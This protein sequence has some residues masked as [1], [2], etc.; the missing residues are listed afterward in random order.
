[1]CQT[2]RIAG[3]PML[4]A[5]EVV[6]NQVIGPELRELVLAAPSTATSIRGGQFVHLMISREAL[7]LRRP[8]SVYRT[9]GDRLHIVY[10]VKGEGTRLL[11]GKLPGDRSMDLI[12]PIG[13]AWPIP[14]NCQRALIVGGGVGAAPLGMLAQELGDR[15][16]E[17]V[18]LLGAQSVARLVG[19]DYFATCGA[20]VTCATDDGS[21]GVT[22][23][24]TE[25]LKELLE[26]KPFDIAYICGPEAMQ[27]KVSALTVFHGIQ[28][29]VSLERLMA[30]GVGACLSCVVPT[31]QGQKRA[32]V[33]GPVFDAE[34]V[35]WDEASL[36]RV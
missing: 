30:C 14:E 6:S 10:H 3:G 26:S 27:V 17:T 4:E 36:A 9:D 11:A 34:E 20:S 7:T 2:S 5:V 35:L 1:M 18:A 32:C 16:I 21:Y 31:T 24:I 12:G 15:G 28:T 8:L 19:Q 23:L 33:D 29:Y 13:R 25:P 22:G